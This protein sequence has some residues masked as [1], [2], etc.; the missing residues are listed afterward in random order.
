[1]RR[2]ALT[3]FLVLVSAAS[4]GRSGETSKHTGCVYQGTDPQMSRHRGLYF[5]YNDGTSRETC[6]RQRTAA[7]DDTKKLIDSGKSVWLIGEVKPSVM[8]KRV[9]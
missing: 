2:T 4:M 6:S 8:S 9:K 7:D 5:D 3:L 1:M